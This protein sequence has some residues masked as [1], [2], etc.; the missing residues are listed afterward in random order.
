MDTISSFVASFLASAADSLPRKGNEAGDH[1]TDDRAGGE[2]HHEDEGASH[3]RSDDQP[4]NG[5]D[6]HRGAVHAI[7]TLLAAGDH[8]GPAIT[9]SRGFCS[10]RSSTIRWSA[11]SILVASMPPVFPVKDIRYTARSVSPSPLAGRPAPVTAPTHLA[12]IG[13][14]GSGKTAVG[15]LVADRFGLPLVDVDE[16]IQARTGQN[17]RDLWEVGG[18]DAY[19]PLE[20]AVVLEALVPSE[21]QV[22]AAPGGVVLDP[23]CVHALRQPHVAVVYLRA[24]P[25]VLAERVIADP[26]PRPLLG[27]NP[28]HVLAGQHAAR[29]REYTELA[30]LVL[31][32]DSLTPEQAADRILAAQIVAAPSHR[33]G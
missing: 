7:G 11:S 26:Q 24:D 20:R 13:L 17:V 3:D 6:G 21:P 10:N 27:T 19:R 14:M 4:G 18:E 15:R 25:A 29:D 23:V 16:S 8:V 1:R 9:G 22:L 5:T 33:T 2:H 32:I 31:P 30:D 12:L 28:H